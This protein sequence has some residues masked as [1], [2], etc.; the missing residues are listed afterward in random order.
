MVPGSE[1]EA[2][3]RPEAGSV[4]NAYA[5]IAFVLAL[6]GPFSSGLLNIVAIVLGALA[7][8]E[9]AASGGAQGGRGLALAAIWI[10]AVFLALVVAAAAILLA[11]LLHGIHV[12]EVIGGA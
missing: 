3:P 6:V 11:I 1:R 10:S 9:I 2:A 8:R 12:V 5:I 4:T 7:L